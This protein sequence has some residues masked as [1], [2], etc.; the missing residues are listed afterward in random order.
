MAVIPVERKPLTLAER[1]YIPQ[2][3]NG[4]KTTMKHLVAP[5]VTLANNTAITG[6][7]WPITYYGDADLVGA[8][9]GCDDHQDHRWSAPPGAAACPWGI[10]GRGPRRTAMDRAHAG[11]RCPRGVGPAG[12][13]G[14]VRQPRHQAVR[15]RSAFG[16]GDR[17]PAV[18]RDLHRGAGGR[19]DTRAARRCRRPVRGWRPQ[20]DAAHRSRACS[21]AGAGATAPRRR[22]ADS[23][24]SPPPSARAARRW[25]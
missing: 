13:A 16:G 5:A 1:T 7:Q 12:V 2:I 21:A 20:P 10:A 22:S 24:T 17:R 18:R 19:R 8:R 11:R 3:I 4:L 15:R 14:P 9:L 23:R 25:T 6:T